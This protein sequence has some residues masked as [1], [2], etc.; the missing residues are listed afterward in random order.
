VSETFAGAIVAAVVGLLF[1]VASFTVVT[2]N[3]A[4]KGNE[5]ADSL[6]YDKLTPLTRPIVASS[7]AMF[8]MAVALTRVWPEASNLSDNNGNV[9]FYLLYSVGAGAAA[10]YG[11]AALLFKLAKAGKLP[12]VAGIT[13]Y[14]S[15]EDTDQ[16]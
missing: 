12:K 1:G 13:F 14:R 4:A 15:V 6:R 3:E 11:I 2:L 7:F 16:G 10:G 9:R 8:L 5:K